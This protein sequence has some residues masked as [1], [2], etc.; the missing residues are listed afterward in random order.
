MK[1][2]NTI[3]IYLG[4]TCNFDCSYCDREYIAKDIGGQNFTNNHLKRI[5]N[6]FQ[7]VFQD[8]DCKVDRIALHGG[9]PFLFTKRMDQI[10]TLLKDDFL[11]K[12]GLF[13][14]ITTNGSLL[15]EPDNLIFLDKWRRYLR[16]TMSYD[17]IYQAQNREK[18]DIDNT[19]KVCNY[20]NIPIHWQ[21]VMPIT[22]PKVFSLDCVKDI[23]NTISKCKVMR[24]INLIPLRHHRGERKFK[25]FVEDLNLTHFADAFMRF[26]NML[27]NMNIMVFIDG[28]YGVTDKN[29]FGDHYKMILSPDG[30]IYPEYDFCEYKSEAYRIGQWTDGLSPN[31]KVVLN[32]PGVEN[33]NI[34]EK[35]KTC[36]SR[37]LCGL[38]YL[39]HMFNEPPGEKCVQ[40]YQ[41]VDAM[42]MYTTKLHQKKSFFHWIVDAA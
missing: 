25:T 18:F 23:V 30:Y 10:L 41:I 27:Y 21:F 24:S 35:C 22:D 16:L 5:H 31:F 11:D 39:H 37:S 7:Q 13:I 19:I 28:N 1:N 32:R 4:N 2:V 36:S 9:E 12:H 14:S 34:P 20:H 33:D 40:F 38:K 8:P 6:F 17:F 26:V 42:V 29:Y 15:L 3:S